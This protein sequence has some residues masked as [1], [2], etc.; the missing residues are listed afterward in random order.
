M[1]R[2]KRAPRHDLI[3]SAAP[4]R[5]AWKDFIVTA[6]VTVTMVMVMT[7]RSMMT[8]VFVAIRVHAVA[9]MMMAIA[10]HVVVTAVVPGYA[11]S[12]SMCLGQGCRG[13]EQNRC[14]QAR[15]EF[16]TFDHRPPPGELTGTLDTARQRVLDVCRPPFRFS[17]VEG[18]AA[19]TEKRNT[20]ATARD[21]RDRS[22]YR[23][24]LQNFRS[25]R[26]TP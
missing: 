26:S 5:V 4:A 15:Q 2:S 3:G 13:G 14:A 17:Q 20:T 1:H 23:K 6:H 10:L 25:I 24:H 7:A 8:D 19:P 21:G 16:P 11:S 18:R 22:C 12:S 9:I